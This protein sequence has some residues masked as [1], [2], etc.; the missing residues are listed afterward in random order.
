[1]VVL[2]AGLPRDILGP[3]ISR[4]RRRHANLNVLKTV[5][6]DLESYT[7]EYANDLYRLLGT[8]LRQIADSDGET[9]WDLSVVVVYACKPDG[10]ERHVVGQ[11]DVEALLAPLVMQ[12]T[13]TKAPKKHRDGVVVNGLLEQTTQLLRNAR[14]VL[15]SIG[16]ELTNR[17]T[18][19]CLLLPRANY[20]AEFKRVMECVH[21]AVAGFAGTDAFDQE[22]KAVAGRLPKNST[23]R[24]TSGQ[25]VFDAP[26]KA[27][28]RHGAAPLW[29]AAGHNDRCVIRGRVRF[30]APYSPKFHYDCTL[31]PRGNREFVSCHG[32]RKVKR[33]QT[34]VNIAPNDNI[35]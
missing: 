24:F 33:G 28:G 29:D 25:L 26:P 16:Q 15:T 12:R 22:L 19:T 9:P 21:G 3:F 11:F 10:S 32:R 30:G 14:G 13:R 31:S 35:R 20:G 17:E 34:Y 1:M 2:F 7:A 6:L 5:P 4:L 18:R 27:R 8:E 23:G